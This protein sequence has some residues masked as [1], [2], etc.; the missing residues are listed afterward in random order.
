MKKTKKKKNKTN[1]TTTTAFYAV[2]RKVTKQSSYVNRNPDLF[3]AFCVRISHEL[4]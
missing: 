3:S 1:K 2:F 4:L